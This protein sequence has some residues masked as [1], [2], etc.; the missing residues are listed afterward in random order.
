[1]ADVCAV[2]GVEPGVRDLACA[3]HSVALLFSFIGERCGRP[4]IV[5]LLL[6]FRLIGVIVMRVVGGVWLM[7]SVHADWESFIIDG[8]IGSGRKRKPEQLILRRKT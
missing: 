3:N 6:A 5:L 2:A 1:M 7:L 8:G 4:V